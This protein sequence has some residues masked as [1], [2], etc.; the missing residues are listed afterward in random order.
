MLL[1]PQRIHPLPAQRLFAVEDILDQCRYGYAAGKG[2]PSIK[3]REDVAPA[4]SDIKRVLNECGAVLASVGA[5]RKLDAEVSE[6]RSATSFHYTGL[7]IDIWTHSGLYPDGDPETDEYV[8]I[9]QEDEKHYYIYARSSSPVGTTAQDAMGGT[10]TV[11]RVTLDA[12]D[13]SSG[14][15][16]KA[17]PGI[18]TVTGNFVNLTNIM[19]AYGMHNIGGLSP[20]YSL[21]KPHAEWWHFESH[22]GLVPGKT[23]FGDVLLTMYEQGGEPPWASGQRTWTGGYFK[24]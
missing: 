3:V 13:V 11:E 7:A 19:S 10:H 12:I 20:F 24:G 1:G 21:S 16:K 17:P 8:A 5:I 4:F 15:Y 9:W 6:G 2:Y 18:K 23:T 22:N 14:T